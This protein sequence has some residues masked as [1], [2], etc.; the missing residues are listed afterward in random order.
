M[1]M[2]LV[3]L[4]IGLA[5]DAGALTLTSPVFIDGERIPAR[6]TCDGLNI[7]PPLA[8][9]A[10]PERTR[11]YAIV[12]DNVGAPQGRTWVHWVAWNIDGKESSLVEGASR[13]IGQGIND[14]RRFG[15]D[16][17]CPPWGERHRLVFRL[18]ALDTELTMHPNSD[19]NAL[20]AVMNGHVLG[21]AHLTGTYSRSR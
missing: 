17:P 4:S 16:G 5:L 9:S 14:F 6:F 1:R 3:I 13:G 8:W 18:Y 15:Y 20:D 12:V 7:S 21:E 11:S 19:R 2:V 10:V